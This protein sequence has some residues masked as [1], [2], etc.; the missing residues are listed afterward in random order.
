MNYSFYTLDV[1]PDPA[2]QL[3]VV[4]T[5]LHRI[6]QNTLIVPIASAEIHLPNSIHIQ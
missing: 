6:C 4:G 3:R 1:L 2:D 5:Q